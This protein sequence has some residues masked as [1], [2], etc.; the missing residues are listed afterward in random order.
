TEGAALLVML[1]GLGLVIWRWWSDGR[2][3]RGRQTI[4]AEYEPPDK[5]RPAQVG[6]LVDEH[7]DTKD[8]TATIVDLAVRGYL[9]ITELP[10][11]GIVKL[12]GGKD[13]S[14]TRTAD[15]A[16]PAARPADLRGARVSC[17]RPRCYQR[18]RARLHPWRWSGRAGRD[19]AR[20]RA[21]RSRVAHAAQD[22]HRRG[23]AAAHARVPS[24][25]GDRRDRATAL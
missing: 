24:L 2:D 10:M 25:H 13:W 22:E 12:F 3:E 8:V 20:D 23:A 5:L 11:I 17:D 7:A 19:R 14:L 4:V 21:A 18:L 9:T 15:K 16:D 1:G 6:L